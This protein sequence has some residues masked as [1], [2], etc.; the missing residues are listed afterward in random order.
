MILRRVGHSG[1]TLLELIV[2]MGLLTLFLGLTHEALGKIM[3]YPRQSLQRFSDR[4]GALNVER[5][6]V[7][8]TKAAQ[9]GYLW[10]KSAESG[11]TV[12]MGLARE[13]RPPSEPPVT[14]YMVFAYSPATKVVLRWTL[15]PDEAKGAVRHLAPEHELSDGEW[16][17]LRKRPGPSVVA[18]NV[19]NFVYELGPEDKPVHFAVEVNSSPKDASG[20]FLGQPHRNER[21]LSKVRDETK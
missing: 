21:W 14:E 4:S 10:A 20:K 11:T 9:E 13:F 6:I 17:A 12:L 16:E 3:L 1:L 19:T 7:S 15:T 2:A 8:S 18:T 5:F